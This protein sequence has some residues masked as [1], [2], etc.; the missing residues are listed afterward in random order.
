MRGVAGIRRCG[1]AAIDLAW[2]AVGPL[3]RL[4]GAR[5]VAVG[6]G[7]GRP[8][9]RARRAASSPTLDGGDGMLDTGSVVAG[10]EA[11]HRQLL[12]LVGKSGTA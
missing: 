12:D 8:A 4:L 6:H 7:R 3:R 2:V 10:N 11:I 1:S 9:R 5:P